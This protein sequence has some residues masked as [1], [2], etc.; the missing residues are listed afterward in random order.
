MPTEAPPEEAG[1]DETLPTPPDQPTREIRVIC[2][3]MPGCRAIYQHRVLEAATPFTVPADAVRLV[4]TDGERTREVDVRAGSE[5][6]V[7]QVE[8]GSD[9]AEASTRDALAA[10]PPLRTMRGGTL[11]IPSIS[12]NSVGGSV[13]GD[14]TVAGDEDS[15]IDLFV[16]ANRLN[17]GEA[18]AISLLSETVDLDVPLA[19]VNLAEVRQPLPSITRHTYAS[20]GMRLEFSSART[21]PLFADDEAF[22]NKVDQCIADIRAGQADADSCQSLNVPSFIRGRRIVSAEDE[23]RIQLSAQRHRDN[24]V[25][26]FIGGRYLG[27]TSEAILEGEGFGV[28]A[29]TALRLSHGILDASLGATYTYL[30]EQ[31]SE[32]ESFRHEFL[33]VHEFSLIAAVNLLFDGSID[34]TQVA[35][36]VGAY[37]RWSRN[38]WRNRFAVEGTDEQISGDRYEGG[39]YA[40]GHFSGGFSGLVG[41]GVSV[42]YGVDRFEDVAFTITVAPMFGQSLTDTVESSQVLEVAVTPEAD[43]AEGDQ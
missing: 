6:G 43:E 27:A 29:E 2:P 13:S 21:N 1:R 34:S 35:P 7:V 39:L 28:A 32:Q 20:V 17:V 40:S 10:V 9:R 23:Q 14:V 18:W 16:Q 15:S 5:G 33:D 24:G 42:P 4:V 8:L 31:N 12:P 26:F 3:E 25:G 22:Q 19:R 11:G 41:F 38:W 36:R 37:F 30:G